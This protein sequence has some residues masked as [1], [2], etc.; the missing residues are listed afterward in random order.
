MIII[1][2]VFSRSHFI[3]KGTADITLGAL[4][5]TSKVSKYRMWLATTIMPELL[6]RYDHARIL[7]IP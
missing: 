2:L 7:N 4:V 5:K 3:W 1:K 6:V